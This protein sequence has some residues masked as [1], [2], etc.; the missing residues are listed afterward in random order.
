GRVEIGEHPPRHGIAD[1][2][3]VVPRHPR[4]TAQTRRHDQV[5]PAVVVH[6]P[7]RGPGPAAEVRVLDPEEV[8]DGRVPFTRV[9]DPDPRPAAPAGWVNKRC[10]AFDS[11]PRIDCPFATNPT[12]ATGEGVG[13]GAVGTTGGVAGG[14]GGG[15]TGVG[16]TV[17]GTDTCQPMSARAAKSSAVT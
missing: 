9:E 16:G 3:A 2:T 10:P 5:R 8:G 6:V 15:E 1:G 17:G 11:P 14:A 12:A 7:H 4:P 13:G